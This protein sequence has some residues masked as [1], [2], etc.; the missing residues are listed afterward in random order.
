MNPK[1]RRVLCNVLKTRLVIKPEKLSVHSSM[2]G[3]MVEPWS[4]GDVINI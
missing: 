3:P 2:F 1:A 4:N